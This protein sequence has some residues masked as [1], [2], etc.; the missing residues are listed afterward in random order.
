M[1][2]RTEVNWLVDPKYYQ[3][4]ISQA[5]QRNDSKGIRQ[6]LKDIFEPAKEKYN[7]YL[8]FWKKAASDNQ[9]D[10]VELS[11]ELQGR[12]D[13]IPENPDVLKD[14]KAWQLNAAK[15]GVERSTRNVQGYQ[16]AINLVDNVIK[17]LTNAANEIDAG[18]TGG[19][20]SR[21]Q[22]S[23]MN[24]KKTFKKYRK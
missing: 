23:N 3:S 17:I 10:L 22:K 9:Q 2:D 15:T 21:K 19:K 18:K 4:I 5:K 12:K 16:E 8:S 13:P 14:L 1:V 20:K 24:K 6:A 11:N 7:S